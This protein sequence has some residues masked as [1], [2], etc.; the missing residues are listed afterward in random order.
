MNTIDYYNNNAAKYYNQTVEMGMEEIIEEFIKYIPADGAILDLGC[1]SG[2]DSVYFMEEGFDVTAVDG[3]KELCELAK[4][5]FGGEVQNM[6]FEELEFDNVFDGVWACASLLH[7]KKSELPNILK[8]IS[9]ALVDDG[10]LY[11]SVKHGEFEGVRDDRYY[12]D[13]RTGEIKD[14]FKRFP[15]FEIIDIYTKRREK[16]DKQSWLNIFV[17]KVA[18]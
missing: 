3:S 6:L 4:I 10:V 1:G 2:R 16:T 13:Y 14:I 12:S 18:L 8:K 17:R 15:E 9:K 7:V 11:M 5:E